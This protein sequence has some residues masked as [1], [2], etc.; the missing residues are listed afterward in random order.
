MTVFC[1]EGEVVFGILGC[2]SSLYQQTLFC[3][4]HS[5]WQSQTNGWVKV[6]YWG[7]QSWSY[8][9]KGLE[10]SFHHDL[11]WKCLSMPTNNYCSIMQWNLPTNTKSCLQ[12]WHHT[13]LFACL[14]FLVNQEFC[15]NRMLILAFGIQQGAQEVICAD[16]RILKFC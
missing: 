14:L 2:W 7:F 12:Y 6:Y 5:M 16:K 4:L 10:I 1:R 15:Y 9:R 3:R 11:C 8:K 13:D